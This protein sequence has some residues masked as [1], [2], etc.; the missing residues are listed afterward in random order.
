YLLLLVADILFKEAVS[1]F[2]KISLLLVGALILAFV[3]AF[4]EKKN[5]EDPAN[6]PAISKKLISVSLIFASLLLFGALAPHDLL[7]AGVLALTIPLL[8]FLNR[9]YLLG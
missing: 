6:K 9:K 1:H 5:L 3:L 2:F 8:F 7:T 4:L